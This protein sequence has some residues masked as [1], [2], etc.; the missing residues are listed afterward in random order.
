MNDSPC[1]D[2]ALSS[3]NVP[4]APSL[5]SLVDSGPSTDFAPA[6][7]S[8]TQTCRSAA[9]CGCSGVY[10]AGNPFTVKD[11]CKWIESYTLSGE[12]KGEGTGAV[13]W[14]ADVY[15]DCPNKQITVTHKMRFVNL[16]NDPDYGTRDGISLI[17]NDQE[18][19]DRSAKIVPG[20]KDWWNAKPYKIRIKDR[21]CGDNIY[22]IFF[23]PIQVTG[24]EHYRIDLYNI[25]YE[26]TDDPALP[27][28]NRK[29]Y[30]FYRNGNLSD[31]MPA[32]AGITHAESQTVPLGR[33]FI[34]LRD[35]LMGSWNLADTRTCTDNHTWRHTG[36]NNMLEPH[37]FAHMLGLTDA[38][39]DNQVNMVNGLKFNMQ[40]DLQTTADDQIFQGTVN[41]DG[42]VV[43]NPGMLGDMSVFDDRD[44]AYALT[45]AYV[46]LRHMNEVWGHDVEDWEIL[47]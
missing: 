43:S 26:L 10:K 16:T 9:R 29:H 5:G 31:P 25:P 13:G 19:Q 27:E 8:S 36:Y 46:I 17:L 28:G 15:L 44:K 37:E 12:G 47:D 6:P 38:Y 11:K 22:T 35:S 1:L 45:V 18:F 30:I 24:G 34:G 32:Q 21:V 3:L 4:E 23:N 41:A 39:F 40:G 20:I 33:S 2:E 14:D 42:T 7:T